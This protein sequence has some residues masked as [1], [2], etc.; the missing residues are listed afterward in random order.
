VKDTE[1]VRCSNDNQTVQTQLH[2]E[3]I[4][5]SLYAKYAAVLY[6]PVRLLFFT[7]PN[8]TQPLFYF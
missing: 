2:I 1:G 3:N 5:F 4:F 8:K 7:E 6:A